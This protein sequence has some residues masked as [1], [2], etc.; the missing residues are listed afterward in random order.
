MAELT[1]DDVLSQSVPLS[2]YEP[3]AEEEASGMSWDDVFANSEVVG[4][5]TPET[6]AWAQKNYQNFLTNQNRKYPGGAYDPQFLDDNPAVAESMQVP[7]W[8]QPLDTFANAVGG[9]VSGLAQT[10][11]II[12]DQGNHDNNGFAGP[13][14]EAAMRIDESKV[15]QY[16]RQGAAAVGES[17]AAGA[18]GGLPAMA[19]WFGVA[20]GNDAYRSNRDR[21]GTGKAIAFGVL[22]GATEAA[23][24]MIGGRVFGSATGKLAD[25]AAGKASQT[26]GKGLAS[27]L[28][29]IA[30]AIGGEITEE[31]ANLAAQI[32]LEYAFDADPEQLTPEV[33]KQRFID[34]GMTALVA[35]G[36]AE[37]VSNFASNAAKVRTFMETARDYQGPPPPT[38]RKG[39]ELAT[40]LK[41][42]SQQERTLFNKLLTGPPES[43]QQPNPESDN[44][45][46]PDPLPSSKEE[47]DRTI[48]QRLYEYENP[49]PVSQPV[50]GLLPGPT[51]QPN[52]ETVEDAQFTPGPAMRIREELQR[53]ATS[54]D[55]AVAIESLLD[56]HA[57]AMGMTLDE[58]VDAKQLSFEKT[59]SDKRKGRPLAPGEVSKGQILFY[60]D[61]RTLIRAFE[62]QTVETLS[63][64]VGHLFRRDVAPEFTP[65][66][67]K[68]AGVKEGKWTRDAEEKFARG[69]S[70]YLRTGN[71]PTR[72]LK[73]AF[74]KFKEW[75]TG[76]YGTLRGTPLDVKISPQMKQVFD[77]L[78]AEREAAVARPRQA[79]PTRPTKQSNKIRESFDGQAQGLDH[80]AYHGSPHPKFDRFSTEK[81]GTGEGAQA[82][83]WGLYFAG[84]RAVAEWYKKFLGEAVF[85]DG[86]KLYGTESDAANILVEEGD[87]DKAISETR[88]IRGM[89]LPEG[90]SP[91][92]EMVRKADAALKELEDWKAR[93]AIEYRKGKL[94]RVDLA[95]KEDEYLDLDK[96]LSKQDDKIAQAIE[97][98]RSL[99]ESS[100]SL[101]EYE[102]ALN[103]DWGDMT[104]HELVKKVL[105]RA[106]NDGAIDYSS[107]PEVEQAAV[108]GNDPKATSLLLRSLGVRG[109][110]YFDGSSRN[111]GEGDR[112][113]VIFDDADVKIEEVFDHI[114]LHLNKNLLKTAQGFKRWLKNNFGSGLGEDANK[115]KYIAN[116]VIRHHLREINQNSDV[117]QKQF[118]KLLKQPVG[119]LRIEEATRQAMD[120]Y[121]KG[122]AAP[123]GLTPQII[124]RLDLMRAHVDHLSREL[125]NYGIVDAASDLGIEITNNLGTYINRT[126]KKHTQPDWAEQVLN[127]PNVLNPARA[128]FQQAFPNWTPDN[129]EWAIRM[130][131]HKDS[132]GLK[133]AP[134]NI[135]GDAKFQKILSERKNFPREILDLMGEV[136]DPFVNYMNSAAKIAQL[137]SDHEYKNALAS[138]GSQNGWWVPDGTMS[139]A[140][141]VQITGEDF[142]MFK[143]LHGQWTSP[144][145]HQALKDA[146]EMPIAKG[147]WKAMVKGAAMARFAQT[148]L[149]M[150][151]SFFRNFFGNP[152]IMLANGQN[153]ALVAKTITK[154]VKEKGTPAGDAYTQK[155][156]RIGLLEDDAVA[157]E[158]IDVMQHAG[159]NDQGVIDETWFKAF[160]KGSAK[161]AAKVYQSADSVY[162]I[163]QFEDLR[164]LYKKANPTMPDAQLD[165]MVADMV[166]NTNPTGSRAPRGVKRYARQPFI[167]DFITFRAEMVR[168]MYHRA[169]YAKQE[170]DSGNPELVKHGYKRIAGTMAALSIPAGLSALSALFY[171]VSREE[172]KDRRRFDP[173]WM[174]NSFKLYLGRDDKGVVQEWDIGF[175][176]P[177]AMFSKPIFAGFNAT[178]DAEQ[179]IESLVTEVADDWI[180]EG[181]V[182][183]RIVDVMRNT[184]SQ[185][186]RVSLP[187]DSPLQRYMKYGIHIA[188]AY[189]PGTLRSLNRVRKAATGEV[190]P[191]N[192]RLDLAEEVGGM[193]IARPSSKDFAT[194]LRYKL[195]EHLDVMQTEER[196]FNKVMVNPNKMDPSEAVDANATMEEGRKKAYERMRQDAL[197]A[198]RLGLTEEEVFGIL[199][200]AL[201]SKRK[202]QEIL[203][204]EL[205]PYVPGRAKV[206]EIMGTEYGE[207]RIDAVYPN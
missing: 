170:I 106:F 62:A 149:S 206:R 128:W 110:K 118:R 68:W 75:L 144:E 90:R 137:I 39:F 205:S 72:T 193:I 173:S 12:D 91:S 169:R 146:M 34:T 166:L 86:K 5:A 178:G 25:L 125:I 29:G 126:Y 177:F 1:W 66:L 135:K 203:F 141:P 82:Y 157:S 188:D 115:L 117:L 124:A 140:H 70:R 45:Y 10:L 27:S 7:E 96:T 120:D 77:S 201:R 38:S 164:P 139:P 63:H 175:S 79:Q 142:P 42:T 28:G 199:E 195:M 33:I 24:T 80:E 192:R 108:D 143:P 138:L 55:E 4:D 155:M 107:M 147:A 21:M 187:S 191:G 54:P 18:T 150:P 50:A 162:K 3:Q 105:P 102:D 93:G 47:M 13:A 53:V 200:G 95:P 60:E 198:I 99:L 11:G 43:V 84:K 172:D 56:S 176:D 119:P 87:L 161:L 59:T 154:L 48:D 40:G 145:M 133:N 15:G 57:A 153:P 89:S 159:F 52:V 151:R 78:F 14:P 22:S 46:A 179:D 113:Y 73:A 44:P 31:E 58:Y 130:L 180:G 134:E 101:S 196:E 17:I 32:G 163:A 16:F 122:G 197:A 83:G 92:Y 167:G 121:L 112:N 37:S 182:A 136:R 183:S 104:G 8:R 36:L 184:K 26:V 20:G 71:A 49:N 69:F 186:G 160:T 100:G 174:R 185:G 123:Q 23:M 132:A 65:A 88:R 85:L 202:A 94:Y 114:D 158:M 148:V 19:T 152:A 156:A 30:K 64:E 51:A 204:G 35:A 129:I 181:L 41:G 6:Q 165:L 67:E 190:L 81:I 74:A 171:G 194:S 131:V 109:N 2:E 76:L 168:N 207:E 98:I 97:K 61:G 116:S 111:Q 103:T 189:T 9:K 127:D